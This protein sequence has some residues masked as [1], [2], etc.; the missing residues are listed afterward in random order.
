MGILISNSLNLHKPLL[1][2]WGKLVKNTFFLTIGRSLV[3]FKNTVFF[4]ENTIYIYIYIYIYIQLRTINLGL[5]DL[6]SIDDAQPK[7]E[8]KKKYLMAHMFIYFLWQVWLWFKFFICVYEPFWVNFCKSYEMSVQLFSS[9]IL[10]TVLF[11]EKVLSLA[12]NA[13]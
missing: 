3:L 7:F 1:P 5:P 8:F 13:L 12:L 2:Q 10:L 9:Q 4:K 11:T 6:A